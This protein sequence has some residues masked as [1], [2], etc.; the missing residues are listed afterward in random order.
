MT[1]GK[2]DPLSGL[3]ILIPGE[4]KKRERENLSFRAGLGIIEEKEFI[5]L[6]KDI[7]K[8][9]EKISG[10]NGE[11]QRHF[12]SKRKDKDDNWMVTQH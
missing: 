11:P 5:L 3:R 12:S 9:E 8:E 4:K 2:S 1:L 10:T 7:L 6:R